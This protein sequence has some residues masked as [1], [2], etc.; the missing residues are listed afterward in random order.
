M[1]VA[2]TDAPAG[3][4]QILYG[5]R[6]E[7]IFWRAVY[8]FVWFGVL[9]MPLALLF[10]PT[11]LPPGTNVLVVQGVLWGAVAV[12]AAALVAAFRSWW[13]LGAPIAIAPGWIRLP[14]AGSGPSRW[15]HLEEIE[16][17]ALD[18]TPQATAEVELRQ[19]ELWPKSDSAWFA[20]L[21][22]KSGSLAVETGGRI[23][24]LPD[25][26]DLVSMP[27]SYFLMGR[28]QKRQIV[29]ALYAHWKDGRASGKPRT[30][31]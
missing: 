3:P 4:V 7:R 22:S 9:I 31:S 21:W 15:I 27:S 23:H 19:H 5:G 16:W 18:P 28:S 10:Q 12:L 14:R 29:R 25:L 30:H 20:T 17:M 8:V 2:P 1:R 26:G 11:Y 24:I 13:A 6:G